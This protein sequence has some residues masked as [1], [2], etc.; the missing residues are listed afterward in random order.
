MNLLVGGLDAHRLCLFPCIW[1]V[2]P[3]NSCL[4]RL[5]GNADFLWNDQSTLKWRDILQAYACTK[6]G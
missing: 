6:L 4:V 3:S 1:T 2:S 5:H